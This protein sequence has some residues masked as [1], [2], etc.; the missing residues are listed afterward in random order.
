MKKIS[1]ACYKL[2]LALE[3]LL[4][5]KNLD[6]IFVSEIVKEAN[7][8]RKTFYRNY[9]DKYDLAKEYYYCF[10][11]VNFALIKNGEDWEKTLV[12]Y[13]NTCEEKKTILRHAYES[14]GQ[15]S[16]IENDIKLTK[17]TFEQLL[18]AKGTY[19]CDRFYLVLW[20]N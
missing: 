20:G 12:A 4:M 15:N 9:I 19:L 1:K 7:V 18:T 3:K 2:M 14:T 6:D 5:K 17:E 16:L 13:F 8:S 11:H 10:Y